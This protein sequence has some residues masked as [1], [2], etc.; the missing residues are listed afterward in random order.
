MEPYLCSSR[1]YLDTMCYIME[2]QF[3][4]F[5]ITVAAQQGNVMVRYGRLCYITYCSMHCN[6]GYKLVL[7][8]ATAEVP[9]LFKGVGGGDLLYLTLQ[10]SLKVLTYSF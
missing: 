8:T 1:H 7:K 9:K 6:T 2:F 4:T 5:G 3:K 10:K